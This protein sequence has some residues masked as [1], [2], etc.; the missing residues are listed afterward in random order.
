MIG[1]GL[2]TDQCATESHIDLFEQRVSQIVHRP[3]VGGIDHVITIRKLECQL[4]LEDSPTEIHV[5]FLRAHLEFQ[6]IDTCRLG[7]NGYHTITGHVEICGWCG[8]QVQLRI[9]YPFGATKRRP[10]IHHGIS[11]F[12][13]LL[14]LL[15]DKMRSS[16]KPGSLMVEG[17]IMPPFCFFHRRRVRS[18]NKVPPH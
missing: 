15:L 11:H 12:L 14:V 4:H 10:A 17:K 13:L 16:L 3:E 9:G 1:I 6:Q 18:A 8:E 2:R 7:L 5:I